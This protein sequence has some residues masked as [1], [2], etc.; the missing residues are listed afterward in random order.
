MIHIFDWEIDVWS[1]LVFFRSSVWLCDLYK[2]ASTCSQDVD[3]K[4]NAFCTRVYTKFSPAMMSLFYRVPRSLHIHKSCNFS[5][6]SPVQWVGVLEEKTYVPIQY[7]TVV[8]LFS[9]NSSN[10]TWHL[11]SGLPLLK[12]VKDLPISFI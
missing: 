6:G 2:Y 10:F 7:T 9:S 3:V 12:N 11:H 8:P 4:S 5:V 1:L